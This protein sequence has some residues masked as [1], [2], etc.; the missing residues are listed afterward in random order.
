MRILRTQT[1]KTVQN[2]TERDRVRAFAVHL[3]SILGTPGPFAGILCI[4]VT[5][6]AELQNDEDLFAP[7]EVIGELGSRPTPVYV[8]RQSA[9][10]VGGA[11]LVIAEHF[12]GACSAGETARTDLRREARRIS[13]LANPHLARVREVSV[14]GDDLVVF[15]E[16]LDGEK[17]AELWKT[18][19][20][21]PLDVGLRVLL[22][23]L[24]GVGALHGLRDSNQQPMKL[25]H[26]ELS[27]ATILVGSDGVG[28]V[29]H[30]VARRAVDATA[31]AASLPYLAPELHANDAHD[32]RADV[33]SIGVLLWELV[34]GK[35]LT[36]EGQEA[37]GVRVRSAPLEAPEVPEKALW[38]KAL[39]PVVT[40]ALAAAAE[41]RWST[42]AVMAA[43]IRK[44]AGLK[45]A[46]ASAAA[47][48][49]RAKFGER[50]KQR[51]TR[52]ESRPSRPPSTVSSPRVDMNLGASRAESEASL[53][54][55]DS[56]A[57][58]AS[59]P[60]EPAYE[61]PASRSEE[62]SSSVLESLPPAAAPAPAAPVSAASARFA[63]AV[64]A[65]MPDVDSLASWDD[66]PPLG[67]P[68]APS[69]A[70]PTAPAF[71][72]MRVPSPESA[73]TPAI[74]P[75]ASFSPAS[76]PTRVD[77]LGSTHRAGPEKDPAPKDSSISI[78]PLSALTSESIPEPPHS[79]EASVPYEA[80]VVFDDAEAAPIVAPFGDRSPLP[81]AVSSSSAPG[82]PRRRTL[83]LGGIAALSIAAVS[84]VAVHAHRTAPA[85]VA[86]QA[87]A[88]APAAPPPPAAVQ[89]P[90]PIPPAQA[91]A[92]APAP[93]SAS[94]TTTAG[95]TTPK[96]GTAP[97]KPVGA[98]HPK[99]P[100]VRPAT[101]AKP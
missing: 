16:F 48:Y 81:P 35:P 36:G 76:A 28:R 89:A 9:L 66:P 19:D 20:W 99:S 68:P 59:V 22:D 71:R 55:L 21:L 50:V 38:A 95:H 31:E 98:P 100:P 79:A 23:V 37:A 10:A 96:K 87:A 62:Y 77:P 6:R 17:L 80:P 73:P 49:A 2:V 58:L 83:V 94:A 27:P 43:E 8:A 11:Q 41:D 12:P 78:P 74:A 82:R 26:G 70:I 57:P 45:L 15:G 34:A 32:G 51:R 91:S 75:I 5:S 53:A 69:F 85:A 52:W 60:L 4:V 1:P 46:A 101:H 64:F 42:A 67:F 24:T 88:V 14:R 18:G 29:L 90:A 72:P 63:A 13:T 65:S 47:A 25:T 3:S 54:R 7:Y 33:F 40:K 30:A 84:V 39:V 44:A 92:Q 86:V 93:A 97:K 56:S 61:V